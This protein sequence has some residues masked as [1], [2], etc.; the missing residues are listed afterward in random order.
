MKRLDL[1]IDRASWLVEMVMEWKEQKG[2]EIPEELLT[3]LS[4]NLF[5]EDGPK[6][7]CLHP[8]E[9]FPPFFELAQRLYLQP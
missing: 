9:A 2:T 7:E 4:R 8:A 5:I 6:E 3:R 1:D